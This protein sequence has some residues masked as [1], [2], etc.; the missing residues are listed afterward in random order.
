M[1]HNLLLLT[2]IFFAMTATAFAQSSTPLPKWEFGF[3]TLYH[4]EDTASGFTADTFPSVDQ[5][6]FDKYATNDR[7]PSS[8]SAF[9][10]EVPGLIRDSSTEGPTF[11]YD[12]YVLFDSGLGTRGGNLIA[13]LGK[14]MNDDY[15]PERVVLV[16]LTHLHGDHIGG[17]LDGETRRFP[18]AKVLCSKPEYDHW[19][20]QNNAAFERIK[21]AYDEDFSGGLTFDEAIRYPHPYANDS[22]LVSITPIH[23]PGHTPGHTV[24]LIESMGQKLMVVGDLLH[25][26]AMQFPMPEVCAR[27][28]M[29]P[30]EAVKSRRRILDQVAEGNI[31]VAGMHI[32]NPGIGFVKKNA[33]GY[34]FTPLKKAFYISFQWNG[35]DHESADYT[36]SVIVTYRKNGEYL[37]DRPAAEALEWLETEL[38]NG[39]CTIIETFDGDKRAYRGGG[40]FLKEIA[41]LSE[42]YQVPYSTQNAAGMYLASPITIHF[43]QV[44]KP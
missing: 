13:N 38:K 21:K 22:A 8:V 44:F 28:D 31:P 19:A 27:Y 37:H 26:A 20:T 40:V 42:R 41:K 2:L 35:I 9:L 14:A 1:K 11:V 10:L 18:N 12:G 6:T 33:D 34:D 43:P 25:A 24:F 23:A 30:T 4:I 5:A 39:D 29:D 16:L 15:H 17:L 3:T 7:I 32:P 36:K